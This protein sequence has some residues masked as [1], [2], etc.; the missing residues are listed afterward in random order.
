LCRA[1]YLRYSLSLR[2]VEEFLAERGMEADHTTIWRWVLQ[3]GPELEK[4]LRRHLKPTNNPGALMR[5]TFE[6]KA[7][8]V[9]STGPSIPPVPPSTSY[10]RRYVMPRRPSACS[11]WLSAIH[12]IR[13]PASSTPIR[14]NVL[15]I[16]EN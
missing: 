12:R 5:H 16:V 14:G 6:S 1:L 11:A 10:C 4:R 13:N 15:R 2:D 7:V 3:Y 9:T 8:G